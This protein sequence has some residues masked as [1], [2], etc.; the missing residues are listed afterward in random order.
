MSA[1]RKATAWCSAIGFPNCSRDF[2]YS[3]AYSSAA[4]AMPVAG[5]LRVL[6]EHLRV[7]D[8]ALAH[9][10]HGRPEGDA[11]VAFFHDEG[12][13]PPRARPRLDRREDDVVLRDAA[14][15]DPRLLAPQDVAA[16]RARR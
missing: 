4:R 2:A 1:R 15:R 8:R 16:P 3:T 5:E 9:L 6:E 12:G 13:D 7:H 11:R 10:P 14:V